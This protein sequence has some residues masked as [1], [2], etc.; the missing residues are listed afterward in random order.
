MG[1]DKSKLNFCKCESYHFI[2]KIVRKIK[3][4]SKPLEVSAVFQ[5]EEAFSA[6]GIYI[7]VN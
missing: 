2:N 1:W 3:M 7:K 6:M 5:L 4:I